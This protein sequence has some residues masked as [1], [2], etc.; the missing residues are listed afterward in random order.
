MLELDELRL[1][2]VVDNETDTLSSIDNAEQTAESAD[3]L[4]RL[5]P[6][7]VVDGHARTTV[8]DHLCCACH[9]FSLLLTGLLN[10]EERSVL[11][12]V[13]PYPEIWLANAE[14]L[15][16]DLS[17][18]ETVF[19]SHWHWDHSGGLAEVLP[20]IVAARKAAGLEPPVLNLHPDRPEVRGIRIPDDRVLLLPAE[21]TIDH[22]AAT[23]AHVSLQGEA[24]DIAGGFFVGSGE[25]PRVTEFETGL[26]GH[27]T[28][29]PGGAFADDPLILDERFL[30]ATVAGRGTSVFSACS[31][32]GIVNATTAA[33]DLTGAPLDL[34]LGGYHLAG[35][36]MEE[37]IPAT[38]AALE[39]LTPALIA[40]GH[41]TGWRAKAALAD[42]FAPTKRFAPSVVGTRYTLQSNAEPM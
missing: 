25:I 19:L 31:H 37:R 33:V 6:A 39:A 18:I 22:L 16:L 9:G 8:F 15:G 13:G 41:C 30:A 23:G 20:A 24:H 21:P 35:K 36:T 10:G 29:R 32:A 3:L 14:R 38:V 28:R 1:V 4:S 12:D 11:F 40:P 5:E 34:V 27:V 17:T 2:V 26:H 7:E 42:A